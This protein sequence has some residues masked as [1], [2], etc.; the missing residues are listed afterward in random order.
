MKILCTCAR[1]II[2]STSLA[3]ILK[4]RGHDTVAFGWGTHSDDTK[5]Y[6]YRWADKIIVVD[7]R[8]KIPDEWAE[9]V[10]TLE[11]PSGIYQNPLDSKLLQIMQKLMDDNGI[12]VGD[13]SL[14]FGHCSKCG[15]HHKVQSECQKGGA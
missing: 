6:M 2:R 9:K 11:V 8:V 3:W 15:H 10:L 5:E 7:D 13:K 14:M 4:Q 1:G 12:G